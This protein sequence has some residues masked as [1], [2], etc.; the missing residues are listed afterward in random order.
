M[1]NMRNATLKKKIGNFIYDIMV[2]TTIDQVYD[3][4]NQMTMKDIIQE[5]HDGINDKI[6]ITQFNELKKRFD[7][8][9]QG[10]PD[11]YDTLLE[12]YEYISENKDDFSALM[13]VIT[14]KVD[15]E[16]GKGLSTN[17]FDNDFYTKLDDLYTKRQFDIKFS[18]IITRIKTLEDQ[19]DITSDSIQYI[20]EDGE[21][22]SIK[23]ALDNL[24]YKPT[25]ILS[26]K[27]NVSSK[28]E[29]GTVLNNIKFNWE[30]EGK[31]HLQT[32]QDIILDNDVREYIL[33][34]PITSNTTFKLIVNDSKNF[35][36]KSLSVNYYDTVYFGSSSQI[37]GFTTNWAYNL[38]HKTLANSIKELLALEF[39]VKNKEYGYIMFPTYFNNDADLIQ[40]TI[41]G[42]L[43]EWSKVTT[44]SNFSNQSGYRCSYNIYRSGQQSLGNIK[45]TI[46][47]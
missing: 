45:C 43:Y 17:D 2:K 30:V 15:K 25:T 47:Q 39:N 4:D 36:T 29:K 10:A 16:D 37:S 1:S 19:P 24:F 28:Q 5:L 27:S 46:S 13:N 42:F 32:L 11:A 38:G 18:E 23:D 31:V 8:L 3:V 34:K 26:F 40:I 21:S 44:L 12:I 6:S 14:K 7:D 20:N 9:M 41:G 22:M 35:D 33:N